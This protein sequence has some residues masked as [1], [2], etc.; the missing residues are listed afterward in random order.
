MT[1]TPIKFGTDGWRGRIAD[2]YTFDNLRRCATGYANYI[3]TTAKPG[4]QPSV[5]IGHDK[6]FLSEDFAAAAAETLAAHGIKVWLTNG[7]TPH[8]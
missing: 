8:P 2:D 3:L 1:D 7:A 4:Q 6:R 5:V